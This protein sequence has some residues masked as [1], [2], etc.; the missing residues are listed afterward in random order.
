MRTAGTPNARAK[1]SPVLKQSMSSVRETANKHIHT[2]QEHTKPIVTHTH[3]HHSIQ[4]IPLRM[5]VSSV[6]KTLPALMEK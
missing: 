2:L 3:T 6:E 1:H 5:G 4:Y